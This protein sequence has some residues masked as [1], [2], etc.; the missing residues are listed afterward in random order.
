MEKTKTGTHQKWVPSTSSVL[1]V[2]SRSSSNT[3][4]TFR[5]GFAVDVGVF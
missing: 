2:L 5:K 1:L 3:Y 4:L